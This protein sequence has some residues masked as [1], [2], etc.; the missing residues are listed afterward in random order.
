MLGLKTKYVFVTNCELFLFGSG[1][2]FISINRSVIV[3]RIGDYESICI[4]EWAC[5]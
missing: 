2:C 3:S 5:I 4:I 1:H